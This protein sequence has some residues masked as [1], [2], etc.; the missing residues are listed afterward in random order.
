MLGTFNDA[1]G[2]E[3]EGS[4]E[5]GPFS[6]LAR[7]LSFTPTG[8]STIHLSNQ[9]RSRLLGFHSQKSIFKSSPYSQH[10]LT[11][12]LSHHDL[13]KLIIGMSPRETA[14]GA[15]FSLETEAWLASSLTP[16]WETIPSLSS[17]MA[18]CT[19]EL[20]AHRLH[21]HPD[22]LNSSAT[23]FPSS[24]TSPRVPPPPPEPPPHATLDLSC[25]AS[26]DVSSVNHSPPP[27]IPS[28]SPFIPPEPPPDPPGD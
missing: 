14:Y 15:S 19:F 13:V 21:L 10:S 26:S 28:L 22:H 18:F 5:L 4:L 27:P 11:L 2:L 9:D 12:D 6:D 24:Q 23:I 25:C 8:K 17:F 1:S 16:C 7:E 20:D 3:Y